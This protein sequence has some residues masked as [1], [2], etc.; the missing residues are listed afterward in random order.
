LS[1][2]LTELEE[3]YTALKEYVDESGAFG[4]SAVSIRKLVD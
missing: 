1:N 2:K 4:E 3:Q